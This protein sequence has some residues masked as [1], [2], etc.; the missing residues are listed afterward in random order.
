[1]RPGQPRAFRSTPGDWMVK[2]SSKKRLHETALS[3][4][5]LPVQPGNRIRAKTRAART[6]TREFVLF[7]L[8]DDGAKKVPTASVGTLPRFEHLS[9]LH[10][11]DSH[12]LE[13]DQ[14]NVTNSKQTLGG[15]APEFVAKCARHPPAIEGLP[16]LAFWPPGLEPHRE[17][18]GTVLKD[19]TRN[20]RLGLQQKWRPYTVA[21]KPTTQHRF[22]RQ[23][24]AKHQSPYSRPSCLPIENG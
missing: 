19:R 17:G 24:T 7:V 12:D 10:S 3:I 2:T 15:R 22:H 13:L 14:L 11:P 6:L 4:L 23:A 8:Q 18:R 21:G 5:R 20:T 1:M 9:L 16:S